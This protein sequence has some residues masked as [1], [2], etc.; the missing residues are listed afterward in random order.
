M[1]KST[2][3]QKT[4]YT[5]ICITLCIVL[6]IA[7]H[8]I[9]KAGVFLSPMHL[10]VL[11]CGLICGWQFGLIC[12]LLGPFLSSLLTGMPS[13]AI[14]PTMIIELMIYGTV[15][16]LLKQFLHT[17]K[18]FIDLYGSLLGAM[19]FGRIIAGIAR[20]VYFSAGSYSLHIW[21]TSYF[22]STL[23]G[24]ILQ[25]LLIPIIYYALQKAKLLPLKNN[26]LQASPANL[27]S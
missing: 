13:M 26:R 14:L 21:A 24:I 22:V 20:A 27:L 11:L 9:P 17:G 18:S 5:A 3:L 10:P 2:S 25:L 6:P 8:P 4:L 16:G 12:G 7:L 15:S 19:L 1:T 23:P